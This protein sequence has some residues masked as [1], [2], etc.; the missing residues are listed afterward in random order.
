[1]IHPT[2]FVFATPMTDVVTPESG[3]PLQLMRAI[4]AT[5]AVIDELHEW[6]LELTVALCRVANHAVAEGETIRGELAEL[7]ANGYRP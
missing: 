5:N 2:K 3:E 4:R 1:M 7:A 6:E